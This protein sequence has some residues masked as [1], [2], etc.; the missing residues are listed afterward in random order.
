MDL[1]SKASFDLSGDKQVNNEYLKIFEELWLFT[2]LSDMTLAAENNCNRGFTRLY[3]RP[4]IPPS[5]SPSEGSCI[6]P[7]CMHP[8]TT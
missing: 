8:K 2:D 4:A 6:E 5:S 7:K 1:H 3:W